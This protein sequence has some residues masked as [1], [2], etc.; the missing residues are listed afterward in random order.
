MT[1]QRVEQRPREK[2]TPQQWGRLGFLV[3]G[4][5]TIFK[6][7]SMKDVFYVPM[8]EDWGLSNAD[9]GLG[10]SVYAMVQTITYFAAPYLADRFSK[11]YL[12]TTGMLGVGLTGLY[13]AT[14]PSLAGFLIAFG[15]LG[16]F[17]EAIFWPALLKAVSLIGNETQQG[18]L[19]GFL[20]A[21]RGVVNVI[22]AFSALGIF[23]LFGGGLAGM[24]AGILFYA[25]VALVVGVVTFF[26]LD[27]KDQIRAVGDVSANAEVFAGIKHVI[28][29]P[30]TW[31]A[32]FVIFFIYA[33]YAGLTYFIP[34]LRDI[35]GLPVVLVGAYGII[36]QYALK[37]VGGPIGGYIADRV[38]NSS[39]RYLSITSALAAVVI[40]GF[41]FLPHGGLPV[42]LG[43]T[44]TLAFGA[45]IFTQR[46]VF[47]A[48]ISEVGTPHKYMG[49][50]MA[51]GCLIGYA[52]SLFAFYIYGSLLDN[53]PGILGYQ[54]VFVIMG[55]F[56]AA[57]FALSMILSRRIRKIATRNTPE[58]EAE[59][60]S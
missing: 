40:I 55:I 29:R 28:R 35:Y 41:A 31:M 14:M 47:F 49:A 24:Q 42:W 21:G 5:G 44:M 60:L 18:R 25:G 50:G 57:G 3:M 38:L 32:A 9:I 26:V 56:S 33:T 15:V 12:L 11:K 16:L 17:G 53:N 30:E 45:I 22:V 39:L 48:P 13:L 2:F 1:T 37:M 27:D 59:T 36:N 46:A 20:E 10:L 7:T 23:A 43:M 51:I 8:Q 52:P 19:F 6:L 58:Q 34:F 54:I 4:G